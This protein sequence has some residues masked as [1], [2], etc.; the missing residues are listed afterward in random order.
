MKGAIEMLK[1]WQ[2]I[3]IRTPHCEDCVMERW[4]GH[5]ACE[6]TENDMLLMVKTATKGRT[7][8]ED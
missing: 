2:K 5:D 6:W 7:E 8:D 4:C 3:C 1:G